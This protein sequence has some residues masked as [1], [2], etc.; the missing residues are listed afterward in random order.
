MKKKILISGGTGLLASEIIKNNNAFDLVAL[1]REEMYVVKREQILACAMSHNPDIFLHCAALTHPMEYHETHPGESIDANI[2]GTANVAQVCLAEGIKMVHISTDWVYPNKKH[3]TEKD[4]LLPFANYG[5][6]KLGA[7]CAVQMIPDHLILRCSFTAY[8]YKHDKAFVDV[9]KSYLYVSDA[10]SM[11]LEIIENELTGIYNVCGEMRTAY[12]F[13]KESNPLV[14]EI[15]R[16][17]VGE[18]IPDQC[19]MSNEKI[20]NTCSENPTKGK[21]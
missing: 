16:A 6:S 13:A 15:R 17:E 21:Q 19:T 18:W 2:V 11:I 5:W 8:P 4:A 7:E 3:N 14:G 12:N 20:K 1:S 9:Y 10:A